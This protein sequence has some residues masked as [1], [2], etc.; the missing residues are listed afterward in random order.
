[1][2]LVVLPFHV[3]AKV[4]AR[5]TVVKEESQGP[6]AAKEMNVESGELRPGHTEQTQSSQERP[7]GSVQ[8]KGLHI[9][10]CPRNRRSWDSEGVR[11]VSRTGKE[12]V[13]LCC[14]WPRDVGPRAASQQPCLSTALCEVS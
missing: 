10:R 5:L 1:M 6:G 4:D 9:V 2:C 14:L 3:D 8:G 12:K 7:T 13:L 11:E